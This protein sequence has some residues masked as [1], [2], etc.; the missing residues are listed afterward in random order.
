MWG[1]EFG[2]FEEPVS[3][4]SVPFEIADV[5][6]MSGR[7]CWQFI[8]SFLTIHLFINLTNIN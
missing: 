1:G 7:L 2:E 5:M 6:Y 3:V 4:H 8:V